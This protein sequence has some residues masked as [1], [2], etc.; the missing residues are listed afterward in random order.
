M[1]SDQ[2]ELPVADGSTA[3]LAWVAPEPIPARPVA[4]QVHGATLVDDFGWLRADN[5]RDVLQDPARLPAEIRAVLDRENAHAT[6]VMAPTAAP[7]GAARGRD[8]RAHGRGRVGRP[9]PRRSLQLLRA[10]S[11]GRPA[12]AH[13]PRSAGRR[14][15]ARHARRRYPGRGPRL[16]RDRRRGPLGRPP[17]AG[18]E[19]R[20]QGVGDPHHQGARPR[21]R[22]GPNRCRA[23]HRGQ[24]GLDGRRRGLLLRPPRRGPARQQCMAAPARHRP[25]PTTG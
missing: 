9:R 19:R 18:L 5:W 2:D 20:R 13:V 14:P 7:P 10:L 22:R 23:P 21:H 16:L 1:G 24:R 17:P 6:A 25:R 15:G 8:A 3:P 12:P 11:R 4:R